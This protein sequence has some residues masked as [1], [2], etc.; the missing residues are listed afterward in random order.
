MKWIPFSI[1]SFSFLI[2]GLVEWLLG[3]NKARWMGFLTREVFENAKSF[4][5]AK[6][7]LSKSELIAPVYFILGGTKA[8]EVSHKIFVKAN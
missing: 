3:I 4:E 8:G 7:S 6:S 1:Y 5:E 2:A